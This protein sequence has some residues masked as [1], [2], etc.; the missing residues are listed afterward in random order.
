MGI[1]WNPP[2]IFIKLSALG[3]FA[4]GLVLMKEYLGGSNYDGKT[5]LND[6]TVIITGSNTGIGKETAH[7]LARRGATVIMACRN[8]NKCKEARK[9]IILDTRNKEV[10]CEE[11]DLASMAS[12]KNFAKSVKNSY[13]RIDILINNAGVMRCEKSATNDGFEMQF[14]SNHLG[15][16]LLTQLLLDKI[17]ACAPSRIINVSSVAHMRGKIHF[18]DLNSEKDYDAG[19]AYNQSKLANLLFTVELAE[20][21]KGTGVTCNAVHPGL[22]NTDIIR[23]LGFAKSWLAMVFIRPFTWLLLKTPRQGAQTTIYAAVEEGLK[24]V[25]GKYF[26]NQCETE[27]SELSKDRAASQRLWAISEHWTGLS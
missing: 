15:H 25:S 17:K 23:H 19:E 20:R 2:R 3:T 14:G 9:E 12:I 16:F 4:G 18:E 1:K 6:K 24:D 13:E 27:S 22:V 5:K 26:S 8:M 10:Y 11:C 7:D 21:L